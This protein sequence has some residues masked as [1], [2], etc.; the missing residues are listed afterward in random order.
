MAKVDL[1]FDEVVYN[2]IL[3]GKLMWYDGDGDEVE[4]LKTIEFVKVIKQTRQLH[5]HCVDGDSFLANQDDVFTFD[6][7]TPKVQ[8]TVTKR[9]QMGRGKK[10]S[11]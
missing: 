6:V 10:K 4:E 8:R 9:K 11:N 7:T 1:T 2:S 3:A 5:I